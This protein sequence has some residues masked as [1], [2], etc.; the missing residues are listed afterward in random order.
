MIYAQSQWNLDLKAHWH[1]T[2]LVATSMYSNIYNE[3]WGFQS[4]SHDYAVIG[5]TMGTHIIDVTNTDSIFS[6]L[7]PWS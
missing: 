7:Y 4:N 3:I 5:S 6:C 1:D 2:S